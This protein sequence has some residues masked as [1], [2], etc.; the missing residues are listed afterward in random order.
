M[1]FT[2]CAAHTTHRAVCLPV[3]RMAPGR[4]PQA[5]YATKRKVW[6][7]YETKQKKRQSPGGRTADNRRGGT[8]GNAAARLLRR[9]QRHRNRQLCRQARDR[10]GGALHD[11]RTGD[12][13]A[14][15]ARHTSRNDSRSRR[16][17]D[18]A[19]HRGTCHGKAEQR[20]CHLRSD[21]RQATLNP[22]AGLTR[23]R[24]N[25]AFSVRRPARASAAR[26]R[27]ATDA[28]PPFARHAACRNLR[29]RIPFLRGGR[30]ASAVPRSG[31]RSRKGCG[32]PPGRWAD[33]RRTG[34]PA[35]TWRARWR[36]PLP[37][38]CTVCA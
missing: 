17:H 20:Q 8:D 15:G 38:R 18:G 3:R 22:S 7:Y 36:S 12:A 4:L 24:V 32:T 14:H 27:A 13:H 11:A 6:S 35:G 29:N 23:Y 21:N 16:R 2:S 30:T 28:L 26:S 31:L 33:P 5:F 1:L 19:R 25:P 34:R 10:H 37:A 9:R